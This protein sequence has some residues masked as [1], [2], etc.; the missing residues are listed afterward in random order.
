M[1]TTTARDQR[2]ATDRQVGYIT[3]LIDA[4]ETP[5]TAP[6]WSRS[7]QHF[8]N[9]LATHDMTMAQA[10]RVI[11]YLKGLPLKPNAPVAPVQ[12]SAGVYRASLTGEGKPGQLY[13]VYPAR[14]HGGMLAK[15]IVQDET[16]WHF[17]YAG[18]ARRFVEPSGRLT[19]E[20]AKAFGAST[21]WCCACGAELTDPDSIAAGIGPICATKF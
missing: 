2:A 7:P 4:R 17:E 3:S 16:G 18:A 11:E 14:G 15:V 9:H 6:V 8:Q 19:L 13:K 5:E 10:S 1:T 20:E 12:L 21:G